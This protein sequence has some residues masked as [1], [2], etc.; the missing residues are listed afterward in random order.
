MF[1]AA[2]LE[3]GNCVFIFVDWDSTV[4]VV[5]RLWAGWSRNCDSTSSR[6]SDFFCFKSIQMGLR[7]SYPSWQR[8][9]GALSLDLSNWGM[10]LTTQHHL[11]PWLR[12]T[13]TV[14]LHPMW[15]YGVHRNSFAFI[16]VYICVLSWHILHPWCSPMKNLWNADTLCSTLFLIPN[17]WIQA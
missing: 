3:I 8:V 5:V 6:G 7:P 15:L 17:T 14:L 11:L 2:T 16:F 10:K 12:M 1:L 9:L 13:G 4:T